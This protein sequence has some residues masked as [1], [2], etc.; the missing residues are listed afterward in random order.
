[1]Q[2]AQGPL[3]TIGSGL[4]PVFRFLCFLVLAA[5]AAAQD[6][7][8][9]AWLGVQL[10]T[11]DEEGRVT[12]GVPRDVVEGALVVGLIAGSPAAEARFQ[13]GDVI[14]RFAETPVR[15]PDDVIALMRARCSG[16]EVVYV[17]RRGEKTIEGRVKLGQRVEPAAVA[18]RLEE[19]SV[20][21]SVRD[22]VKAGGPGELEFTI[23]RGSAEGVTAGARGSVY[24]KRERSGIGDII[25]RGEV[26]G[27]EE[28]AARVRL[29]AG[30][31]T[32]AEAV[33]PGAQ[34]ELPALIPAA[35]HKGVLFRL[36]VNGIVFLD[37]SSEL[38]V[39]PSELLSARTDEVEAAAVARMREAVRECAQYCRDRKEVFTRAPFRGRSIEKVME[40]ASEEEIRAFLRFVDAYPGKY[41]ATPWKISETFATWLI[42]DAPPAPSDLLLGLLSVPPGTAFDNVA[43]DLG[44]R[45]IDDL[46]EHVLVS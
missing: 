37:N 20:M 22:I 26:V 38:I 30:P 40:E 28:G 42:N 17:V 25:G 11:L 39:Q 5:S 1:M 8:P 23:G 2:R 14:V 21:C 34:I 35:V 33:Q 10:R 7:S 16:D 18:G 44:Q 32:K 29:L 43:R 19:I 6:D 12:Y 46:F 15:T 36:C 3:D 31:G 24:A 13:R 9:S 41:I 27:V 4:G 45:D